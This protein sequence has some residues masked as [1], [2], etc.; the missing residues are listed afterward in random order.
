MA[1]YLRDEQPQVWRIMI[2]TV[3]TGIT[4]PALPTLAEIERRTEELLAQ[5]PTL[6]G[7]RRDRRTRRIPLGGNL[8][9]I[10][11]TFKPFREPDA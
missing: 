7:G 4:S 10:V 9:R 11:R 2:E 1:T 6:P 5:P 8:V 3:E